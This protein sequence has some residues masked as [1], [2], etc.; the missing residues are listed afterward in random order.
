MHQLSHLDVLLVQSNAPFYN[1]MNKWAAVSNRTYL[2]NY[3]TNFAAC[4]QR[5]PVVLLC[6]TFHA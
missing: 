3:V 5:N 6:T 1:D 4:E 2:W